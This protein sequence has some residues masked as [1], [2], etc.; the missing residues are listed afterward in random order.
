MKFIEHGL[1]ESHG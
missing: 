1:H